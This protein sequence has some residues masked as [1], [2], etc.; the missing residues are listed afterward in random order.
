MSES[1]FGK[2]SSTS[3]VMRDVALFAFL[4]ALSLTSPRLTSPRLTS[5]RLTSPSLTSPSSAAGE[6][7]PDNTEA[8]RPGNTP[9]AAREDQEGQPAQES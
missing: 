8:N 9:T 4:G 3:W 2:V 1:S 6:Q 7:N 5:P